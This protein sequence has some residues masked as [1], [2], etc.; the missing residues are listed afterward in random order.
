MAKKKA[1]KGGGGGGGGGES[2]V[3]GEKSHATH[4]A[5]VLPPDR[6]KWVTLGEHAA[7]A[8]RRL[9]QGCTG[10]GVKLLML[11]PLR[12]L[13]CAPLTARRSLLGTC[14]VPLADPDGPLFFLPALYFLAG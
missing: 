13:H 6:E 1:K 5:L 7:V 12:I 3:G 2:D 9:R 10:D 8:D 11:R 4:Q 14:C